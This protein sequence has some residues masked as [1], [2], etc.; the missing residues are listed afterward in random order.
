MRN[1]EKKQNETLLLY[2]LYLALFTNKNLT[3]KD[4]DYIYNLNSEELDLFIEAIQKNLKGGIE[5]EK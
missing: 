5:D 2:D 1:L 4:V 3:L